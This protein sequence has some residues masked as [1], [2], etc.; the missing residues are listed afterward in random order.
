MLQI[1]IRTWQH[2]ICVDETIPNLPWNQVKM[3]DEI[4]ALPAHSRS[5]TPHHGDDLM[6]ED[7]YIAYT[8]IQ[9]CTL[10]IYNNQDFMHQKTLSFFLF[11]LIQNRLGTLNIKLCLKKEMLFF[12]C[13][14]TQHKINSKACVSNDVVSCRWCNKNN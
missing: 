6:Q 1:V 3:F 10:H 5:R 7:T 8:H 11:D 13:S 2:I 14:Q 4:G 12:F 9:N